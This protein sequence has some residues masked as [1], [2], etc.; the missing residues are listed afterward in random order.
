MEAPRD[1]LTRS[2]DFE[3]T[4]DATEGDG[5]TLEG[6]GAVFNQQT[7]INSWEGNFLEQIAPGAFKRTLRAKTPVIQFDHGRHPLVGSIPLGSIEKLSEDST[8]LFIRARLHDNWMVEPVRD[9]IK[10]GAIPGMSFR[11]SVPDGKDSWETP[12]K[13]GALPVRTIH[14]VKL[15]ELGPVVFPAYEQTT[16]GVRTDDAWTSLLGLEAALQRLSNTTQTITVGTPERSDA[17]GASDDEGLAEQDPD[18]REHS[19]DL[20]IL[21]Q[22]RLAL[23]QLRSAT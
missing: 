1:D 8:G 15:Y 6:Y 14:E 4:R 20:T 16:V 9:A 7:E 22:R 19:G 13:K 2:F 17:D 10:S 18:S 21:R 23:A 11:F 5:L 12:A 3:L